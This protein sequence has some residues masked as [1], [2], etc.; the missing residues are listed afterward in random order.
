VKSAKNSSDQ[1]VI[2]AYQTISDQTVIVAYQTLRIESSA[3]RIKSGNRISEKRAA[4]R[5][6]VVLAKSSQLQAIHTA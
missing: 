4:P 5:M 6:K 1:T 2:V 3:K